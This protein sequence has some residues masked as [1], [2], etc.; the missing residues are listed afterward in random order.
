MTFPTQPNNLKWLGVIWMVAVNRFLAAAVLARRRFFNFSTNYRHAERDSRCCF[1]NVPFSIFIAELRSFC[2]VALVPFFCIRKH[3]SPIFSVI[4]AS[5]VSVIRITE[6]GFFCLVNRA[7]L[8]NLFERVA[9]SAFAPVKFLLAF[10]NEAFYTFHYGSIIQC[11]S[12][13]NI[14]T[15]AP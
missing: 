13:I 15:P 8:A 5:L 7:G 10:F 2:W 3:F 14:K 12:K 4:L 11:Q 9:V 1:N 6:L